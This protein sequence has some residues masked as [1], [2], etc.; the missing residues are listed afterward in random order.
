MESIY[1]AEV[2]ACRRK[3]LYVG[4]VSCLAFEPMETGRFLLVFTQL[5]RLMAQH[6]RSYGMD[7]FMIAVHPQHARFYRRFMGMEQVGPLRTY[8]SVQNAPAVACCLDFAAIDRTRPKCWT[9]YFGNRLSES[10]IRSRPMSDEE[11]AYFR[12]IAG[13]PA[14]H[15]NPRVIFV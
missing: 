9:S 15:H 5:T 2:L 7:Q 6:A 4:E 14:V 13:T 8:P 10:E 3:N 1:P 12:P 11:I